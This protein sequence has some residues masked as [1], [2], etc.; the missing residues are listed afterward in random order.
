MQVKFGFYADKVRLAL[1]DRLSRTH[2]VLTEA[3]DRS[4]SGWEFAPDGSEILFH[5]EDCGRT[6]LYSLPPRVGTPRE[7]HRGGQTH[8]L[9]VSRD[10]RLYFLEDSLR[11][12]AEVATCARNGEGFRWIS[13]FNRGVMESMELGQVRE[14]EFI[15]SEGRAI[16]MFLVCPSGFDEKRRWPLVHMIHGGPHGIFGDQFHFRWNPHLFA[17]S[18]YVAALV[19]FHGSTSWGQEFAEC[20]QGGWGSI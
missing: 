11:A 14:M 5:A 1:Y 4:A 16:H 13:S 10:G 18:G 15:G 19:N 17:A 12:P 8:D 9:S 2:E 7:I 20:I 3:W 6:A